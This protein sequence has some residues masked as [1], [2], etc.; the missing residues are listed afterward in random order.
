L[1]WFEE[2][3]KVESKGMKTVILKHMFTLKELEE[4][5]TL[6]IDLKLDVREEC[7]TLGPV[8]SVVLYDLEEEGVMMVRF[9][10]SEAASLCIKV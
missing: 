3:V 8:A 7:E 4:D 5:P 2:D 1:E 10:T 9:K 6:L